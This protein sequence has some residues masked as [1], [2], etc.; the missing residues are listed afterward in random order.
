MVVKI[1]SFFVGVMIGLILARALI[2]SFKLEKKMDMFES[3][4]RT[5]R[6]G[7]NRLAERI[8]SLNRNVFELKDEINRLDRRINELSVQ[9]TDIKKSKKRSSKKKG[10]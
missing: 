10:E 4:L 6:D 9:I 8:D 2:L 7:I 3:V 1:I 5:L